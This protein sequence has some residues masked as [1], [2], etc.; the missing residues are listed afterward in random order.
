M[1]VAVDPAG[2]HMDLPA[3]SEGLLRLRALWQRTQRR[4]LAMLDG[5]VDELPVSQASRP[6]DRVVHADIPLVTCLRSYCEA[7][8]KA[9]VLLFTLLTTSRDRAQTGS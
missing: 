8:S 1:G 6:D 5:D 9:H 4:Y 3:Q 7:A 2:A